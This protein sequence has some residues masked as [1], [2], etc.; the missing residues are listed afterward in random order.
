MQLY[1]IGAQ[2]PHFSEFYSQPCDYWV[3]HVVSLKLGREAIE[4]I[5]AVGNA[6]FKGVKLFC[7]VQTMSRARLKTFANKVARTAGDYCEATS[8]HGFGYWVY[9]GG[10]ITLY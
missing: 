5:R 10:E 4:L 6:P 3:N 7:A 8:V 2:S 9:E 1:C